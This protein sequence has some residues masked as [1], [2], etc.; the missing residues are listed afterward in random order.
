MAEA[1]V[2]EAETAEPPSR[3]DAPSDGRFLAFLQS[4]S[5][6]HTI[7]DN[8]PDT[9]GERFTV[10]YGA[11]LPELNSSAAKAY[12]VRGQPALYALV[13]DPG[14]PCRMKTLQRLKGVS[15]PHLAS[16]VEYGITRISSHGDSRM[17]IICQRPK[18]KPLSE[19][20]AAMPKPA[21]EL[22][23]LEHVIRPLTAVMQEF[24]RLEIAHLRINPGTIYIGEGAHPQ[25][26]LG[27]AVSEPAGLSQDYFCETIERSLALPLGKGEGDVGADFYAIGVVAL[28]LLAGKNP[29]AEMSAETYLTQRLEMGSYNTLVG[30]REFS[31]TVQDLLRGLLNDQPVERWGITQLE[32]WATGKKFHLIHPSPPRE[33]PRPFT[34]NGVDCPNRRCLAK[35]LHADWPGAKACLRDMKLIRWMELSAL[36]PQVAENLKRVRNETGGDSG[37]NANDDDALVARSIIALDIEGP[38]RLRQFSS[39]LEGIG[40]LLAESYRSGN[41]DMLQFVALMIGVELPEFWSDMQPETVS[42]ERANILW[43]IT[44]CRNYLRMKD[45][46]FGMERLLY[47]LNPDLHCLSEMVRGEHVVTLAQLLYCLDAQS[48]GRAAE[49]L[50]VDRH[51]AAFISSHLELVKP[52][53]LYDLHQFPQ[54]MDSRELSA[55]VLLAAA[56]KRAGIAKLPGLTHWMGHRLQQVSALIHSR[57]LKKKMF[58]QLEHVAREGDLSSLLAVFSNASL[59]AEDNDGFERAAEKYQRNRKLIEYYTDKE[60]LRLRADYLGLRLSL[61]LAYGVCAVT[62]FSY[63]RQHFL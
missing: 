40:P 24:G 3:E 52:A 55:L 4:Y 32:Q 10:D 22:F 36:K 47:D 37:V 39:H 49:K 20:L 25:L 53:K 51:V 1:A 19:V 18:G 27:E 31:D 41:N 28:M 7:H 60:K 14:Y 46:G 5:P 15:H 42:R 33:A 61:G 44:K 38:L 58:A 17:V 6:Q 2:K 16:V 43:K 63:F 56:Q 62:L 11:T 30:R 21:S 23:V 48:R 9:V 57:A 13:C 54:M 29:V 59:V 8:P 26:M 45:L 34:V 12:G 35:A 50:P